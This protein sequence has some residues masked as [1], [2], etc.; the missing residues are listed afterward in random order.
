MATSIYAP[1]STTL[2]DVT[3]CHRGCLT[4]DASIYTR[5]STTLTGIT[6]NVG[7]AVLPPECA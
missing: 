5:N 4:H 1:I 6:I 2:T 7:Y 3:D